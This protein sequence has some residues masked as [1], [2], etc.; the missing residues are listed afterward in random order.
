MDKKHQTIALII[1]WCE[2]TKP[3]R[4]KIWKNSII[5]SIEVINC[6]SKIIKIFADFLRKQM[7][8]SNDR[9]RGQIQIHQGDNKEKIENY[10]EEKIGI[11]K[12]QFDKT[13]IR[14]R[15]NKPNKNKGTFKLRLYDK[16]L[17]EKLEDM[18]KLELAE[19]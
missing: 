4:S 11:P 15:G 2:G 12:N 7:K 9:L 6:D 19:I 8:V 17:Y 5:K 13:I 1:W 16:K 18:L 10:W 14:P 3:R